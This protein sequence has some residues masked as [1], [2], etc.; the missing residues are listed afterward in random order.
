MT[1]KGALPRPQAKPR[2]DRE[3]SHRREPDQE[4]RSKR[5]VPTAMNRP[6]FRTLHSGGL[7][8]GVE[9]VREEFRGASLPMAVHPGWAIRFPW[10]VQGITGRG[11][12]DPAFDFGLFGEGDPVAAEARWEML[13]RATECAC[14]HHGRQLHGC[15]VG[16]HQ[17]AGEP[18]TALASASPLDGHVTSALSALLAVTVADCVP[19]FMVHGAR[20][21]VAVLH[22]G[23]RGIADGILE[24]GLDVLRDR[25]GAWPEGVDLHLGPAICRACYQ[26]GPEVHQALGIFPPK[27]PEPVDLRGVLIARALAAGVPAKKIT[28]SAWCTRCGNSQFFSHR[29]GDRE[30]QVAFI[31]VRR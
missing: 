31:G 8:A 16:F 21:A 18:I 27:G 25:L 14:I 13:L 29:G 3:R 5:G 26:V 2:A 22:G 7:P 10:L 30:R 12:V 4:H 15:A 6:S 11:R 1:W 28:V 20:R 9:I 19:I 24:V 23:W 17:E